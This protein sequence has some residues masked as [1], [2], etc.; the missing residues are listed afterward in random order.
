MY[1]RLTR[2]E[3]EAVLRR[4]VKHYMTLG[5]TKAEAIQQVA[6]DQ[7][8]DPEWVAELVDGMFGGEA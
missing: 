8:L 2:L 6:T 7:G 1:R 3:V 5:L 4:E